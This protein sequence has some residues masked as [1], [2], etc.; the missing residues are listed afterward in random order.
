M[1]P[2]FAIGQRA[3]FTITPSGNILW[4]C[5]TLIN[6]LVIEF[7]KSK[8]GLCAIA[9]SHPHYYTTMNRWADIFNC[10]IYIHKSDKDWVYN[11]GPHLNLWERETIELFGGIKLFNIDG[12]FPGSTLLQVPFPTGEGT[13]LCGDTFYISPSKNTCLQCIATQIESRCHCTKFTV[14]NS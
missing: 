3:L 6:N 13:I 14:S 9:M 10:P 4:D 7:I 11:K 2:S 8:G 12:H 5:I 1:L